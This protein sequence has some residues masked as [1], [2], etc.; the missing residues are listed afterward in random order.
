MNQGGFYAV[1]MRVNQAYVAAIVIGSV[2]L[3]AVIS[4]LYWKV[5]IQPSGGF[6]AW[7]RSAA[8]RRLLSSKNVASDAD[9]AQLVAQN[10]A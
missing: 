2:L 3:V 7:I 8:N 9:E 6:Q 4:Y 1:Q 5:R 10:T